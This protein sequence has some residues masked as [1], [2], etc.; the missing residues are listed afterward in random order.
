MP[1]SGRD[2]L[3]CR[4]MSPPWLCPT[5]MVFEGSPPM[6]LS[7]TDAWVSITAVEG[8]STR[9]G[10]IRSTLASRCDVALQVL[11]WLKMPW[12]NTTGTS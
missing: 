3:Q 11:E 10:V 2:R 7:S 4:E 9:Y 1:P 5:A 6:V 12:T 8:M